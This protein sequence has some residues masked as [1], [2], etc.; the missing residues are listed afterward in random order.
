MMPYYTKSDYL[1]TFIL[2]NMTIYFIIITTYFIA[3]SRPINNA[4]LNSDVIKYIVMHAWWGHDN[5]PRA[6][7]LVREYIREQVYFLSDI[8]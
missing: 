2:I 3:Y 7:S 5:L 4:Q 1:W 6:D 8:E